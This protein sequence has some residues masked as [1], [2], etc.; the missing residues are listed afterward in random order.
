MCIRD[1]LNSW[2]TREL[3][4][5]S[6]TTP[7]QLGLPCHYRAVTAAEPV[8]NLCPPRHLLRDTREL[9][10]GNFSRR[11]ARIPPARH[12]HARP[13]AA[14]PAGAPRGRR[15]PSN[16]AAEPADGELRPGP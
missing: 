2:T 10:L 9:P 8:R 1:S 11:P 3:L 15:V 6:W 13:P 5:K 14:V 7:G 12:R 4:D 16:D